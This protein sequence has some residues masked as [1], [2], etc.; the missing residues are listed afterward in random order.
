MKLHFKKYPAIEHGSDSAG[1][2]LIIL[3]G[4]FGAGGNW[5][6]LSTNR[7]NRVAD[8]YVV[9]QRN[10]GRSPHDDSFTFD[11][12]VGDLLELLDD[13]EIETAS[14][15]GHSMG[16][17]TAMHFALTH[18]DRVDKLIIADISPLPYPDMHQHIFDA[19]N[20]VQPQV[21]GTRAEVD[22]ILAGTIQS[23]PVRQFL[24]KNLVRRKEGLEWMIN[25]AV[26]QDAY[27]E[28]RDE[29]DG[30]PPFTGETLFLRGELSGYI[31]DDHETAILRLFP[32][33]KIKLLKGAG[34][35]M[36]ADSPDAFADAVTELLI[37]GS[38]TT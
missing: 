20:A 34:H 4:L 28:L 11:D 35:W 13:L 26:I 18:Q 31:Q 25:L 3:H 19:L 8:V 21:H 5:H 15:L 32:E 22:E 37:D 23:E 14:I 1:S 17:K 29:V 9:D 36:H 6:S 10:H 33:A 2:P 16:G 7:F 27:M 12:M 38:S 24:M 30:W